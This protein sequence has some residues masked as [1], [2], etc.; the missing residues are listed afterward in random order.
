MTVNADLHGVGPGTHEVRVEDWCDRVFGRSWM[1]MDGSPSALVYAIRS[2]VAGLPLDN[3]VV[4]G[5][6]GQR[7]HLI[8]VSEIQNGGER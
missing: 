5:K 2:T 3:E 8:H 1:G 7:G 6:V 4:Y